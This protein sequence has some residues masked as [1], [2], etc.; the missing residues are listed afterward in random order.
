MKDFDALVDIWKEQ[1]TAP[2]ADYKQIIAQYK[3]GR[4]KLTSKL[5]GEISIMTIAL[6][7][8]TYILFKVDF[9]LWTSYLGIGLVALCCLYF[10]MMQVVNIKNISD[11][12]TAF[13]IKL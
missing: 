12:N 8:I 6:M 13:T 1:K 9:D 4:K 10:V 5:F 7:A 3:A 11:S 2:L